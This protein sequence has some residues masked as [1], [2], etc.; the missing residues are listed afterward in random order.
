MNNQFLIAILLSTLA[1][2]STV[3][4]SIL[5]FIN[6]KDREGFISFSLSFSLSVMLSISILDIIPEAFKV[7]IKS[8]SFFKLIIITLSIILLI[9]VLLIRIKKTSPLP[10]QNSLY[11]VGVVN[12]IILMLHNF[13]E[14][15]A[16]FMAS[17]NDIAS[18]INL[19]IAIMLHNIPEGISIS[20]PI[21]LSSGCKKRGV[22]YSLIAGLS[23][24][25]GAILAYIILHRFI[26]ETTLN[27]VLLI[28]GAIMIN[29][30]L[31]E[32]YPES[33]KYKR[34]KENNLGLI[35]G[36]ILVIINLMVL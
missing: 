33:I 24:P 31:E 5:S 1:G 2:L 16:T 30:A 10:T 18:G 27:I 21:A 15:I 32:I 19:V 35:L 29:L 7:L 17:Y 14:G 3:I 12:T 20:V 28:V 9:R 36:L 13:P 34:Y 26:S 25:I 8:I 23:E 22:I 11:R 4:G 6:F